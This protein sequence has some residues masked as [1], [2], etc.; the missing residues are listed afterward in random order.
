M[1][2]GSFRFPFGLESCEAEVSV[3]KTRYQ[4][5]FYSLG[6]FTEEALE[7]E[8]YLFVGR[9]GSGKSSLTQYMNFQDQVSG[10]I[11]IDVD[12]PDI[13]G[14]IYQQVAG[15]MRGFSY[16]LSEVIVNRAAQLW[17]FVIWS[18]I[19]DLYSTFDPNL[20]V[21]PGNG[22][23][24]GHAIPLRKEVVRSR[25]QHFANGSGNAAAKVEAYMAA[26]EFQAAV[27]RVHGLTRHYPVI[28]AIDSLERYDKNDDALMITIA[29]LIQCASEF[30]VSFV[31]GGI[32]VKVFIA[33]EIF[34]HL[35]EHVILNTA[36]YARH[37]VY[38]HWRPR[39]LVHLISWR[40][41]KY[42]IEHEDTEKAIP[43]EVD[44]QD[45]ES[46]LTNLWNP[47]FGEMLTNG[48]EIPERTFPYILRHTQMRPRQLVQLCN[49]IAREARNCGYG[50]DYKRVNIPAIVR[51]VEIELADEVINS[52][53][54]IYPQISSV[55]DALD[56]LP[57]TFPG[58]EL[59]R[60]AKTTRAAWPRGEYSLEAFRMLVAELGI[61]GRVRHRDPMGPYVLGDFEYA[62]PDRLP[63]RSDDECMV[64]PM[65]Y[66]KLHTTFTERI[67]AFPF[68]DHPDF[69]SFQDFHEARWRMPRPALR[70]KAP[71]PATQSSF[72]LAGAQVQLLHAALVDAFDTTSL[73]LMVRTE[74]D[75][76]LDV[77]AGGSNRAEVAYNLIRWAERNN[78]LADL[79]RGS[80]TRNPGN[81]YL[82]EAAQAILRD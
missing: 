25:L 66:A 3:L 16:Q 6:R 45:F 64:H 15:D 77:I 39:D 82:R 21:T 34:P 75:E 10:A 36:K 14:E 70:T 68:P 26:E 1:S 56:K 44:W 63:L 11:C 69:E 65:F 76:D 51:Q 37:P 47:Y 49:R 9:R 81:V 71:M 33:A 29:G 20:A 23:G 13:Y 38:L 50:T 73:K 62:M 19:F 35:R 74:L 32:H 48:Q 46:V 42:L 43:R 67:V 40:F 18:L 78:R 24:V 22:N 58:S 41:W 80:C 60:I 2:E 30:N 17:R 8:N 57:V 59:D 28:V 5:Y 27:E 55:I 54:S 52:Y 61:I 7:P 53:A 4:D 79:I 72:R 31:H 12:E